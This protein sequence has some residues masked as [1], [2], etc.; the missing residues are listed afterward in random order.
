MGDE[1]V[2]LRVDNA[3]VGVGSKYTG[4]TFIYEG[5]MYLCIGFGGETDLATYAGMARRSGHT[6]LVSPFFLR[7]VE[8]REKRSDEPQ[9]SKERP[10]QVDR[11][12]E[13]KLGVNV[14]CPEDKNLPGYENLSDFWAAEPFDFGYAEFRP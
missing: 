9:S 5:K 12:P 3:Y 6:I 13:G 8:P 1:D 10:S 14:S 11:C 4:L 7:L 2:V